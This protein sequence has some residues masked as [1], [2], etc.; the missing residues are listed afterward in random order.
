MSNR[1]TYDDLMKML[2]HL[3]MAASLCGIKP[4][5]IESGPEGRV[6]LEDHRGH[7]VIGAAS[8]LGMASISK[9]DLYIRMSDFLEGMQTA[10]LALR[11]NAR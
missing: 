3:N 8:G 5:R 11:P 9:R 10:Y 2:D 6:R 1:I 4:Y 7:G